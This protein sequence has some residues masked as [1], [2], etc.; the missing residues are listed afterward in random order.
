[1]GEGAWNG[2]V[3]T[4]GNLLDHG[5]GLYAHCARPG[6][7]HGARLDLDMLI[8]RYGEDYVYINDRR[9]AAACICQ[10]CGH[11]G[12]KVNVVANTRAGG[13]S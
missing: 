2:T 9:I 12:A 5:M 8:E 1:M 7:G 13:R 10:K 11:R 3:E 6:A 4:L